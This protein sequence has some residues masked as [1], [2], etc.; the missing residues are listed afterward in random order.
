MAEGLHSRPRPMIPIPLTSLAACCALAGQRRGRW[1]GG[2]MS[3]GVGYAWHPLITPHLAGLGSRDP[4]KRADARKRFIG[5]L[6]AQAADMAPNNF[7][8]GWAEVGGASLARRRGLAAEGACLPCRRRHHHVA[9]P[10]V[11]SYRAA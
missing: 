8:G 2:V 9:W 11:V 6:E 10:L 7:S 1:L 3:S 5:A 4:Q